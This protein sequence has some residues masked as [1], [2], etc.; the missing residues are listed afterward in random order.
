MEITEYEERFTKILNK[1]LG[2]K[3][4]FMSKRRKKN[5]VDCLIRTMKYCECAKDNPRQFDDSEI[6]TPE[7]F[8]D[9]I[10]KMLS[11]QYEET[12]GKYFIQGEPKVYHLKR[13]KENNY[14]LEEVDE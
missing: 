11:E 14:C 4:F 8:L 9:K 6:N 1:S 2:W 10:A 5:I 7:Q 12:I 3:R 13:D